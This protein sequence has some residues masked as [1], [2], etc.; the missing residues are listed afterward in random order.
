VSGTV[1]AG[2][3]VRDDL[4]ET[5]ADRVRAE[6]EGVLAEEKP[7]H[8][9]YGDMAAS[10]LTFIAQELG[11]EAVERAWRHVGEDVWRPFLEQFR[12]GGDTAGLAQAFAYSLISHRYDFEAVE[13]DDRWSFEVGYCTSG[14]R[15]VSEG[16]VA[17][18]A[19]DRP[20]HHR[21]GATTH[22]HPWTLGLERFPYYDVHS[23]LWMKLLPAE[24]GWDVMD[25][26]YEHNDQLGEPTVARYVI[27]K[28]PRD[29]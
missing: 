20:G 26:E 28:Q 22:A 24:W 15:M 25:V 23:A 13:H 29:G 9:L 5:S 11:E 19:Q 21:F 7:I 6:L 18:V 4:A 8:D 16:K 3:R 1:R 12:A 10:M 17:G 27:Y 2:G 14:E